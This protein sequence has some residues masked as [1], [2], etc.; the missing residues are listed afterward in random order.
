MERALIQFI[1]ACAPIA[2]LLTLA[3]LLVIGLPSFSVEA[4]SKTLPV[5]SA[6]KKKVTAST[7]NLPTRLPPKKQKISV[8]FD[9]TTE[10]VETSVVVRAQPAETP[11]PVPTPIATLDPQPAIALK[12]SPTP[13]Q[14]SPESPSKPVHLIAVPVPKPQA[15]PPPTP[16]PAPVVTSAPIH[17]E[18]APAQA[19][20]TKTPPP[21]RRQEETESFAFIARASLMNARYSEVS[22]ELENGQSTLALGLSHAMENFELRGL[23]E[24]G[25]GMDQSVTIQ[26]TRSVILRADFIHA[27][28]VSEFQPLVGAGL[29][30]I[31][32]S[33]R[34]Y[35]SSGG[36]NVLREHSHLTT[37]F[38]SPMAGVRWKTAPISIDLTLEYLAPF[39]G[40]SSTYGGWTTALAMGY[41]FF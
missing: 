38:V 29:G 11:T 28:A 7:T 5:K 17:F 2:S 24:L 1:S 34:S 26:N 35:R 18:I 19:V 10:T 23:F 21:V 20:K 9:E 32:V 4:A 14:P 6:K 8:S 3:T 36:S 40:N 33:L 16:T 41:A 39:S 31:D 25:H 12:P 30:F 37:G 15:T 13:P 22:S 27:F